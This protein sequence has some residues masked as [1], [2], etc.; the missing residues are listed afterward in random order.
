MFDVFNP[1]IPH[2]TQQ[3]HNDHESQ[4]DIKGKSALK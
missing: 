3:F 4:K 1:A 2:T